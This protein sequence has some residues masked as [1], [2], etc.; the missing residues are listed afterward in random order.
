MIEAEFVGIAGDW[1]GNVS[2]ALLTIEKFDFLGIKY[3]FQL[4]DFGVWG[5]LLAHAGD[6]LRTRCNH[7]LERNDQRLF[8]TLG[9]H[10][11]YDLVEQFSTVESCEFA[12]FLYEPKAPRILYFTR[13]QSLRVSGRNFLSLGGAASID[14][15]W[16]QEHNAQ[17][18]S[19]GK[20]WWA[21]ERI[22]V[23]DMNNTIEEAKRL[24]TVDVFL[25]HDVFASAPLEG[26]H[27]QDHEKWDAEEL[28]FAQTSRDTLEKVARAVLPKVWLH[29]HYH[30]R[31]EYAVELT[32]TRSVKIAK[33]K[34]TA[35][36]AI[37]Q[38]HCFAKDDEKFSAGILMLEDLS[39]SYLDK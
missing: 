19:P 37:V 22:S 14:Y 31:L 13:G 20:I 11:N 26:T 36:K 12:G 35:P 1:H 6:K 25:A 21:Q 2:H 33:G 8:V 28:A 34:I 5:S 23:L 39:V 9:N 18:N 38:T 10:E 29:G 27:R 4:G 32:G 7:F 15:K 30:S 16:R 17:K 3:I 24:G